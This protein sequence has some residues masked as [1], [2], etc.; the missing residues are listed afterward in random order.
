MLVPVNLASAVSRSSRVA[1]F[2]HR[3]ALDSQTLMEMGMTVSDSSEGTSRTG[4]GRGDSSNTDVASS[5]AAA[6]ARSP[7]SAGLA[8]GLPPATVKGLKAK[9]LSLVEELDLPD[10]QFMLKKVCAP[11]SR[12][13]PLG[14]RSA[15]TSC[16][17]G[18]G[19]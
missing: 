10:L 14:M 2:Y 6:L 19:I 16:R 18:L 1:A 17:S 4:L 9:A 3:R 5:L 13:N 12:A 15:P 11:A 7:S 8:S